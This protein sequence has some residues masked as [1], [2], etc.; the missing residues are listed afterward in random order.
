MNEL[1]LSTTVNPILVILFP[2]WLLPSDDVV[3]C[4][5]QTLQETYES[6]RMVR[7]VAVCQVY[8]IVEV[9]RDT[10][11]TPETKIGGWLL[12]WLKTYVNATAFLL[13][14]VRVDNSCH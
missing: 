3:V 5:L 11:E 10:K 8:V 4:R 13:L 9:I 7:T 14:V 6:E 12:L 1:F 2:V